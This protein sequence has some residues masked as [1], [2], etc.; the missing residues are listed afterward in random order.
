MNISKGLHYD[1]DALIKHEKRLVEEDLNLDL[2][3]LYPEWFSYIMKAADIDEKK[4]LLNI[5][6]DKLKGKI[7]GPLCFCSA[8]SIKHRPRNMG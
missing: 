5:L 1:K 6:V 2:G 8:W 3:I 4:E 7:Q